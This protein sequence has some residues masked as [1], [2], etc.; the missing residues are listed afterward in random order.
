MKNYVIGV[1]LVLVILLGSTIYRNSK[2]QLL[3]V[4]P[5][6][7]AERPN[8]QQPVL[9]LYLFFSKKNCASCMRIVPILNRLTL[10]YVV[11]GVVPRDEVDAIPEL[12]KMTQATFPLVPFSRKHM[13][14]GPVMWPALYGV[15]DRGWVLFIWPSYPELKQDLER[16]L[17]AFYIHAVKVL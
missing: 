2:N 10:P 17:H 4:F 7:R 3:S 12:R 6:E 13:N 5:V 1:L 16:L 8:P 9:N 11:K 15:S 14:L